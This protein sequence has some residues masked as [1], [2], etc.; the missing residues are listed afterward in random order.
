MVSET[1]SNQAS[2]GTIPFRFRTD[3]EWVQRDSTSGLGQWVVYDPVQTEYYFL[4]E[5]ERKI[6]LLIDGKKSVQEIITIA[7]PSYPSPDAIRFVRSLIHRMQQSSL[8][9]ASDP[10]SFGTLPTVAGIRTRSQSSILAFKIP[11]CDPSLFVRSS[12][13]IA[14][15]LFSKY[16]FLLV[17]LSAIWLIFQLAIH[18]SSLM[19]D[20]QLASSVSAAQFAAL[21]GTLIGIKVL[22]ELGHAFAGYRFG[23]MCREVGIFMFL[24]IPC[25]YCDMTDSWRVKEKWSRIAIA[26]GGI[27][28]EMIVA[29]IA[30]L[31][32]LSSDS[33]WIRI[34]SVQ[35]MFACSISTVVF[36]ANPLL[37]Y[38]GY[39]AVAD[40]LGIVNLMDRARDSW[41]T[42]WRGLVFKNTREQ[43][44]SLASIG[45]YGFYYSLSV[46]YRWFLIGSLLLGIYVWFVEGK[47]RTIANGLPL[48]LMSILV[49]QFAIS[50]VRFLR[51]NVREFKLANVRWAVVLMLCFAWFFAAYGLFFWRS[52][53]SVVARAIVEPEGVVPVY[54]AHDA[55]VVEL[56]PDGSVVSTG[57]QIARATSFELNDQLLRLQGELSFCLVRKGQWENRSTQDPALVQSIVELNQKILGLRDQIAQCK[58]EMEQLTISSTCDG[59]FSASLEVPW[60]WKTRSNDANE[61]I[62]IQHVSHGDVVFQRGTLLGSILPKQL[63]QSGSATDSSRNQELIRAYVNERDASKIGIGDSA[64]VYVDQCSDSFVGTV[65]RIGQEPV[66]ELPTIL[67]SDTLYQSDKVSSKTGTITGEYLVIIRVTGLDRNWIRGGL[68]TVRMQGRETT[69]AEFFWHSMLRY[70]K[71]KTAPVDA[72][73]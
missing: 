47:M 14:K 21:G 52:A 6:A 35:I 43:N 30:G 64:K 12:G 24:G 42:L 26:A 13:P 19:R 44:L 49:L 70:G 60:N 7:L 28:V 53:E 63:S 69:L 57:V 48:L 38:D 34:S 65:D 29:I 22:H 73:P 31:V 50:F 61:Q 33:L 2:K 46:S 1:V 20:L 17:S 66:R 25:L 62:P 9:I 3:L 51:S 67:K 59:I 16:C 71:R 18:G 5:I 39:F 72:A 10:A 40:L 54:L 56:L 36:N 11:I 45:L 55:T 23:I 15:F 4:N 32:W 68:A 58:H 41:N 37:R 8:L 27:Y